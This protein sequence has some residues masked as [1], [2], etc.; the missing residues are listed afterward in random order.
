MHDEPIGRTLPVG[1]RRLDRDGRETDRS[2]GSGRIASCDEARIVLRPKGAGGSFTRHPTLSS[3]RSADA[4]QHRVAGL[5]RP[6]IGTSRPSST[7]TGAP[8]ETEPGRGP[9]DGG[10]LGRVGP[11]NHGGSSGGGRGLASPERLGGSAA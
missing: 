11:T 8:E 2:A 9:P 10:A 1:T 5:G 3:L 6:R 4:G 7:S